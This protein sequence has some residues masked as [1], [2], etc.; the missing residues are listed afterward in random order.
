MSNNSKTVLYIAVSLDG[1]IAGENDNLSFLS[2]VEKSGEDYG[3]ADFMKTVDSVVMGKRTYDWIIKNAPQYFHSEKLTYVITHENR[4]SEENLK[5]YSGDIFHLIANLK[6][7]SNKNIFIE[8]GADIV[9]QLI[10]HRLIDEFYISIIPCI[11]GK[12]IKLFMGEEPFL[13]LRL[14]DVKM[15]DTGLVQLHYLYLKENNL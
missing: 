5:F 15:Y 10:H 6:A 13:T 2:I 8:G 3:Y 1:Y 14:N 12:G 4:Q 7:E 11:I 9:N